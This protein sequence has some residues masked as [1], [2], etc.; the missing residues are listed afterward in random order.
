VKEW[1]I[2]DQNLHEQLILHVRH[3]QETFQND[4]L[5]DSCCKTQNRGFNL[6]EIFME[7][8]T[9]TLRVLFGFLRQ[10]TGLLFF[11]DCDTAGLKKSR[12]RT[13]KHECLV[14]SHRFIGIS[15]SALFMRKSDQTVALT[16]GFL[17]DKMEEY[18]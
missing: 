5:V 12:G 3:A 4:D 15:Y 6:M 14:R 7:I 16:P 18:V 8:I 9:N 2:G 10:K 1:L 11:N 13:E 17:V